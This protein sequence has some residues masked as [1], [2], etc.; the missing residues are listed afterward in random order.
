M[1]QKKIYKQTF[2]R[3]FFFC[4]IRET[5]PTWLITIPYV[6]KFPA[7]LFTAQYNDIN[8]KLL[9]FM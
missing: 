8:E 7:L 9:F 6:Q 4:K 2:W 5:T 1:K 3:F